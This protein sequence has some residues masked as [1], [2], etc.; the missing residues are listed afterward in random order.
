MNSEETF[1]KDHL[2]VIIDRQLI[3]HIHITIKFDLIL[4]TYY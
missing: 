1:V 3:S 4:P 2:S